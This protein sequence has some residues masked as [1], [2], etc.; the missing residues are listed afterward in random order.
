MGDKWLNS[1]CSLPSQAFTKSAGFLGHQRFLGP[2]CQVRGGS[3]FQVILEVG[4]RLSRGS[5]ASISITR[6]DP[7]CPLDFI[8]NWRTTFNLTTP[9]I[10][11]TVHFPVVVL[12]HDSFTQPLRLSFPSQP[13][14]I[15]NPFV[16]P[17]SFINFFTM[18]GLGPKKP[19]SRKGTGKCASVCTANILSLSLPPFCALCFPGLLYG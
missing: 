2:F 15:L 1:A 11:P 4:I 14:A 12:P 10:S 9:S 18:V 17:P 8:A 6:G 5:S 19:P 13:K 16:S 7:L 3:K